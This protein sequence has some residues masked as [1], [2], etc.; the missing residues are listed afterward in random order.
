MWGAGHQNF[1]AEARTGVQRSIPDGT[2][3]EPL[4]RTGVDSA[5]VRAKPGAL[6]L[7]WVTVCGWLLRGPGPL[8]FCLLLG[9]PPVALAEPAPIGSEPLPAILA[10]TEAAVP[11]SAGA[12]LVVATKVFRPFV[13]RERGE[14]PSGFTIELWDAVA[15]QLNVDT[16]YVMTESVSELLATVSEGRADVGA[17]GITITAEREKTVNFS[18]PYFESGLGILVKQAPLSSP[19]VV[20][21]TLFSQ[22]LLQA[23]GA[24]MAIVLAVAH[25]M[26]LVERKRSPEQFP[27]SYRKGIWEACGGRP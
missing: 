24:V 5:L 10:T 26:W 12:E 18:Y 17:A 16:R 11:P 1:R 6:G 15:R 4:R 7:Q 22:G 3:Q 27:L 20:L 14:P 19:V 25:V 8:A 23:I 13:M 21:K 9:W 2:G